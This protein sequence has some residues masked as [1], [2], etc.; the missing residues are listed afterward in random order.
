MYL[1]ICSPFTEEDLENLIRDNPLITI[2]DLKQQG[3]SDTCET[4]L[5]E[6]ACFLTQKKEEY[7]R[8]NG[9]P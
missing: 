5:E 3:I 6:V 7:A 8:I 2:N 9:R 4:C 1:C